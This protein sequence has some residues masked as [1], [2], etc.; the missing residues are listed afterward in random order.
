VP[1]LRA[2]TE[3]DKYLA[4]E[5]FGI[6]EKNAAKASRIIAETIEAGRIKPASPDQGKRFASYFPFW[7]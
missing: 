5:R 4:A 2:G 3:N 1:L 6:D 7:A